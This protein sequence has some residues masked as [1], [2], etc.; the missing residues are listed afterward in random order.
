MAL[1]KV[2]GQVVNTSTDL[3]VGVLT[4]TTASFTGNVS[5]GGTLTY[6]DVTNVDSVG[7][8]TARNG[9]EVTDKGVQVGTGATVDSAAANTLTFL[10]N[11]SESLRI[12]S[13][14]DVGIGDAAPNSNYGTNLSVHSTATDGARL[15]LSDGTTG[16]GNTDGLD[17]I[18]TGGVAYFINR[19]NANMS[20]S[21]NDTE[22]LRIDSSGL[23]L[24]GT[25]TEGAAS[26]DELTLAT[27]GHTG[28]TIR[29]GTSSNGNIYFSD[30]TSGS[31]EYSGYFQYRHDV[32]AL[33]FGT[34]S[35][36][37]LRIDSSGRLLLGLT[38]A[39]AT[40]ASASVPSFQIEG[41]GDSD[42]RMNIGRNSNGDNGPEIHLYKTRGT[43]LGSNTVVQD[44]D[45]LGTIG[46]FGADGSDLFSRGAEI[47]AAVDGTPGNDDMPTRLMFRTCAD[48]SSS[49]T[50]RMRIDSSGRLLVGTQ[51]A[52]DTTTGSIASNNS[53][54]G[55]RLALGGNPSSAGASIGE[56]FGWWNG[57]KIGG[58]VIASGA[59]TT[60]KD[61]GEL[62]FYTSASGPNVVERMRIDRIGNVGIGEDS[63]AH[64]LHVSDASTPEIV[65]EDTSNNC[66]AYL[67]SSDTNGR[68]GTLSNHDLAFRTNDTERMRI[69][70]SGRLL[71]ACTTPPNS[72]VSAGL[73]IQHT[74]TAN[75]TL[76]RNDSSITDGNALGRIDFYGN[77]GGT[78]EHC[79]TIVAQADGAH[80]DGDKPTRLTFGT[81]SDGAATPTE[82]MRIDNAGRVII[83]ATDAT[84]AATYADDLIIGTTSGDRG[85]TIVSSSSNAGSI[86]FSDGTSA[87][88]KSRGIIQ[89]D[90]SGNFLR[91]YTNS[92]ERARLTNGGEF[93]VGKTTSGVSGRGGELRDGDNDYAV[94]ATSNGHTPFVVNRNTN[95]GNLV[96]FRQANSQEGTISVSGS[97]VTYGGGHL[98]RWSQLVGIST[99]IK[100]DRPT[101]LR[102]SVLSN[103]DEM[104]E[105]GEEDN[106]QL[107]RMK[108]SDVE[109]DVNVS[110]VFVRWDDDDDTYTNDFYCAMTGDFVIRIAQGTT[111]AR[112]DLLM[113]AGDGTAKPQDDDIVRS[114]TI[115]KVT[116][117][118]VSTTYSDGSY[119]VP[120]V[121]MAC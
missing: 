107:N 117:T 29:S 69:D 79:A 121:L 68:I 81:S 67:G 12:T 50:E 94:V 9:I 28:I 100:S 41:T 78:F 96:I 51:S 30:A 77:D 4:A 59:D 109:G 84:N 75:I 104:C 83:R 58:L 46:F 115:A 111:V 48:G 62:L 60:N 53:A 40:K 31:G 54:N 14:G 116:S 49:A 113:S 37:R 42:S 22:R 34:S 52:L 11:G 33:A 18:S 74:S 93:I 87:D 23:L 32:N 36:E 65:V 45:F 92:V 24:L 10:T 105:W 108:I 47:A 1:T 20:F 39:R 99:N 38:S 89:Y 101:I 110:G 16:K 17:I 35:S 71:L 103:L 5:V 88:E 15:K 3:T 63:P 82:R 95:D 102:G 55:G 21:T 8:I 6:E 64:E 120:C 112:G 7:L 106:E 85:M 119:C 76:A 72:G 118:T 44:N 98:A 19:E 114:K 80:A 86:N 26:A 43:S 2:T 56:I 57:N 66:K 90:H 97:T 13:T 91:L 70:S 25:T 61:D 27:T 73:Q